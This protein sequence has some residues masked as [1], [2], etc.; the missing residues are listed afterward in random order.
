MP[1][2]SGG[3][4]VLNKIPN[5][6]ARSGSDPAAL[7][8]RGSIGVVDDVLDHRPALAVGT[9]EAGAEL[10]RAESPSL[11]QVLGEGLGARIADVVA[12][13]LFDLRA[14]PDARRLRVGP[15]LV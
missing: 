4:C 14:A 11:R 2:P 9:L 7:E 8:A 5:L 6:I 12:A 15:T 10:G 3:A 1:A 13:R